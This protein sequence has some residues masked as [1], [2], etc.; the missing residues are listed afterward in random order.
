MGILSSRASQHPNEE[1]TMNLKLIATMVLFLLSASALAARVEPE[2]AL[3][4]GSQANKART[5]MGA[6]A[7]PEGGRCD[8]GEPVAI[9]ANFPSS[10][11]TVGRSVCHAA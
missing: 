11:E 10:G 6:A 9:Q 3:S 5:V 8:F 7:T 1:K 4:A 2:D